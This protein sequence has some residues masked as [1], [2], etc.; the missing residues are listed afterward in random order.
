[1]N[2]P[3]I[4]PGECEPRLS[5]RPRPAP[6]HRL[7]RNH[8]FGLP[9][10]RLHTGVGCR[11]T[12]GSTAKR[13]TGGSFLDTNILIALLSSDDAR[14]SKAESLVRA[15]GTIS[16]QVLNEAANVCRRKARM[17]W[18]EKNDFLTRI[19]ALLKVGPLG[20]QTH[21]TGLLP[22]EPYTLSL[23]DAMIAAAAPHDGCETLLS[24]DMHHGSLMEGRVRVVDPFRP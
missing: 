1:V 19:N 2:S 24:E 15:G 5:Q 9:R 4:M 18:T 14:A 6:P 3:A 16:V 21:E 23:Y 13:P 22:A 8:P 10:R 11:Q 7:R 12:S 20:L 17:S